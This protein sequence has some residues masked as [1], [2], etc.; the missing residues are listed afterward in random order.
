MLLHIIKCV[1]ELKPYFFFIATQK[2]P[3]QFTFSF[4]NDF[5]LV[6]CIKTNVFLTQAKCQQFSVIQKVT[7]NKFISILKQC[8]QVDSIH[9]IFFL[10]KTNKKFNFIRYDI[11]VLMCFNE[12]RLSFFFDCY[13]LGALEGSNI[14]ITNVLLHLT[15]TF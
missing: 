5:T 4:K 15:H 2:I 7:V 8:L 3:I 10:R 14:T 11:Q 1:F 12:S 6:L 13:V 9:G